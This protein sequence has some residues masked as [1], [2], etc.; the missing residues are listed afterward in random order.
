MESL[1]PLLNNRDTAGEFDP[2]AH[3]YSGTPPV[4]ERRMKSKI[5]IPNYTGPVNIS[6][7]SDNVSTD[8]R[9]LQASQQLSS[10]FPFN[11]DFNSGNTIGIGGF[12]GFF[13]TDYAK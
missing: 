1:T 9:I 4:H 2:K 10:E 3:G 6:L 11:L 12:S 7:P 8:N 13:L 5:N